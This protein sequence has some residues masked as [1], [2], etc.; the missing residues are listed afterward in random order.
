M[1]VSA[2][3]TFLTNHARVLLILAHH[4]RH[5]LRDVAGLAGITE[6]AAQSI[7]A[8]LEKAGYLTHVRVGRRN[9][10]SLGPARWLRHPAEEGV[11]VA[12]LLALVE[13]AD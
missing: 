7:V 12:R 9:H 2:R 11:P 6:R 1:D 13:P 5:R 3:W 4:P 10:Y 8:D